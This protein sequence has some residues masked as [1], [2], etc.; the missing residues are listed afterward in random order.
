[1]PLGQRDCHFSPGQ[2]PG[3]VPAQRRDLP[4]RNYRILTY[5]WTACPRTRRALHPVPWLVALQRERFFG[6][7]SFSIL[8]WSDETSRRFGSSQTFDGTMNT[9]LAPKVINNFTILDPPT[10]RSSSLADARSTRLGDKPRAGDG[11]AR[12]GCLRAPL[13]ATVIHTLYNTSKDFRHLGPFYIVFMHRTCLTI[14]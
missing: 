13:T 5:H 4:E 3:A 1:M 12:A 6:E 9:A 10:D 14:S 11:V 2:N 8:S 7:H